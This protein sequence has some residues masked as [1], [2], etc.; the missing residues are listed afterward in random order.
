MSDKD[1][2]GAIFPNDYKGKESHPDMTGTIMVGG[3][4]YA[5]S[6]WN[7]TAQ[8]SGKQYIGLRFERWEDAMARREK[9]P[10]ATGATIGARQSGADYNEQTRGFDEDDIPF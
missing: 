9:T 6:G 5:V 7:N 8:K 3:Q 10:A 1:M 2:S 4:K